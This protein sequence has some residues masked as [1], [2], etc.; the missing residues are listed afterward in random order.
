MEPDKRI[1]LV[2]SDPYLFDSR[3]ALLEQHGYR[4]TAVHTIDEARVACEKIVCDLVIVDTEEDYRAASELCEEIKAGKPNINVA[5]ITWD[6]ADIES[7]CPDEVIRRDRGP[8]ELLNK[9]K[10]A[11][12]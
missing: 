11:L 12:A 2:Q 10:A 5:V 9:V 3:K 7:D 4:V 8:K 6:A 1:V